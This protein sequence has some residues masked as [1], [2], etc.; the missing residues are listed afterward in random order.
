MEKI[1]MSCYLEYAMAYKL[2]SP[3]EQLDS[4]NHLYDKYLQ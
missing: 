2:S 3:A 4:E 1:G